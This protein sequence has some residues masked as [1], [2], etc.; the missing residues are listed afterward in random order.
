M[1][2]LFR[3]RLLRSRWLLL[4]GAALI[5]IASLGYTNWLARQLEQREK[6][7]FDVYVKA[8]ESI[9]KED[10]SLVFL[11]NEIVQGNNSIPIIVTQ[12]DSA[13]QY[14]ILSSRN[15]AL[16]EQLSDAER[17]AV[18][19]RRLR[20][21]ATENEPI[22]VEAAGFQYVFYYENSSLI[23]RLEY[24]PYIQIAVISIFAVLVSLVF[25]ASREAEQ[26]RLWAGLAKETAHQLGTPISGLLAWVD[27][28]RTEEQVDQSIVEELEKDA[29][30]LSR[31]AERFSSI[32][33][34]PQLEHQDVSE[35]LT[36]SAA[37]LERRVPRRVQLIT[38]LD[39][40]HR[41][42][43]YLNRGLFEWVIENLVKNAVDAMNG[44]GKITILLGTDRSNQHVVM[45]VQDEGK[46]ISE[47]NIKQVFKPGF[48]T[49]KK[50][51]HKKRGW[52][53][54]LTLVKR[55]V[56]NYHK[57]K[58]TVK[59]EVGVGTTFSVWLPK[60]PARA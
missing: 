60:K 54:G 32:G 39:L 31:I 41:P 19:Q 34:S 37:Y 26:N 6:R 4:A 59:S 29:D 56:E 17:E 45:R 16:D 5:G 7:Q 42:E 2:T 55:I 57:G 36:T 43:A 33:S 23:G 15:V 38:K 40:T 28:L 8:Q 9:L 3:Q 21:M 27:L 11:L 49:K 35:V 47:Q 1:I 53:L 25:S 52:G 20:K 51:T 14:N 22:R 58:I 18:L 12:A 46:G 30:R 50:Y 48:S 13:G 24:F 44:S 10:A